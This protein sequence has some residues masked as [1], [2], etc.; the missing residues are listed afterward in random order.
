[1]FFGIFKGLSVAKSYLRPKSAHLKFQYMF[2]CND[3]SLLAYVFSKK[4][5]EVWLHFKVERTTSFVK[6]VCVF[7]FRLML[8]TMI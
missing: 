8:I 6:E 3:Y 4:I 2:L 1:M 7:H 5:Y